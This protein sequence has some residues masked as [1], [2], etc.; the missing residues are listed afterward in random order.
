MRP[1]NDD[2]GLA[3]LVEP[4]PIPDIFCSDLAM[5]EQLGPCRRLIFYVDIAEFDGGQARQMVAKLVIPEGVLAGIAAALGA[6]PRTKNQQPLR[7]AN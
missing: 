1:M 6:A 5:V 2:S 3:P 4:C 7:L